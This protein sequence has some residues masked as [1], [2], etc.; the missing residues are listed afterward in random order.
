[1]LMMFL[2]NDW[3]Q[4]QFSVIDRMVL[5]RGR[6]GFYII[7]LSQNNDD[8]SFGHLARVVIWSD[9]SNWSLD[10]FHSFDLTYG[11]VEQSIDRFFSF[12]GNMISL[13]FMLLN[14]SDSPFACTLCKDCNSAVKQACEHARYEVHCQARYFVYLLCWC[15][16][17]LVHV[18]FSYSVYYPVCLFSILSEM[19]R[20][21]IFTPQP[22]R[23]CSRIFKTRRF[24]VLFVILT[25]SLFFLVCQKF[26]GL[27][28]FVFLLASLSLA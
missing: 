12:Y 5:T 9:Q 25:E 27:V 24:H 15:W 7:L 10:H 22:W 2:A 14:V 11:L 28:T 6:K 4:N 16:L 3:F 19:E 18:S 20:S 21:L 1:M 13:F 8:R 23:R 26:W 17:F